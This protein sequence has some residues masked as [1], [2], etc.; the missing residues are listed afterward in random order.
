[1]A[2]FRGP[3]ASTPTAAQIE[4]LHGPAGDRG[5]L[6][7]LESSGRSPTVACNS[8]CSDAL[9]TAHFAEIG[10]IDGDH[11]MPGGEQLFR[12][13]GELRAA[14]VAN[15]DRRCLLFAACQYHN[16]HAPLIV[17]FQSPKRI[18]SLP[19]AQL[20]RGVE[21]E[22]ADAKQLVQAL[23]LRHLPVR[24][25]TNFGQLRICGKTL[26]QPFRQGIE[27][28]VVRRAAARRVPPVS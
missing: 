4:F 7:R 3:T 5:Q 12:L 6:A 11:A 26:G 17:D 20:F 1:M 24:R 25:R 28:G 16:R 18:D 21:L 9:G 2:L 15:Q 13:G 14:G 27:R 19:I 10:E 23:S 8:P 22:F